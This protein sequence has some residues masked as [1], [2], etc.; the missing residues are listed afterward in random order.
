[1]SAG[2]SGF[3]LDD[4]TGACAAGAA[5]APRKQTAKPTI[6]NWRA[7]ARWRRMDVPYQKGNGGKSRDYHTILA[8]SSRDE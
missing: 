5:N 8:V 2:L 3:A 6:N 4:F 1:M 7:G